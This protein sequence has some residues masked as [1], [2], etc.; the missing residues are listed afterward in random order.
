MSTDASLI[1]NIHAIEERAAYSA[2]PDLSVV[3]VRGDDRTTWLNGQ[4]TNDI[5]NIPQGKSVQALA[6]N[7]RGK[8][9]AELYVAESGDAYVLLVP[10]SA[11]AAL[12]ESFDRYIIMEDVTVEP[13]PQLSVLSLEGTL[14]GI[15]ELA[16]GPELISFEYTP[17]GKLGRPGRAFIGDDASIAAVTLQL[18]A[19]A[20]QLDESAHEVVRLRR[21]VPRYGVDFDDH[22][23]PQEVGLMALVSFNK[24]CYL[25]QEVVCTL[26]NRGKLSRH[27]CV[28]ESAPGASREALLAAAATANTRGGERAP[29]HVSAEPAGA[30]AAGSIT[31]AVWDPEQGRCHVLAYVRRA[32]AVPGA[33]LFVGKEPLTLVRLVG[34][35]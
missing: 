29:L 16:A 1:Q 18:V 24:G 7:V 27:L 2:R 3:F 21:A 9:M 20:A 17:Y 23:Y 15:D 28:L 31:S 25:G 11:Q 32:H 19:S 35:A 6:V 13:A 14:A 4:L 8:I 12:L 30:D 33:T 5:R 22:N 34:E 26:E 10:A